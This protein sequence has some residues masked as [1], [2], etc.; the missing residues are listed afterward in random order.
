MYELNITKL[1]D[2]ERILFAG[3]CALSRKNKTKEIVIS[4]DQLNAATEG[5]K[6]VVQR[7]LC[8]RYK[9]TMLF[10]ETSDLNVFSEIQNKR[11]RGEYVFKLTDRFYEI[12]QSTPYDEIEE[13]MSLTGKYPHKLYK[14]LTRLKK[15]GYYEVVPSR[16]SHSSGVRA[17][18][19]CGTKGPSGLSER[20]A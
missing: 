5:H 1:S 2:G 17:F 13:Y 20:S 4:S 12:L 3:I 10:A 14:L 15:S 6:D 7:F 16:H 11:D 8:L 18:S 19:L 9:D